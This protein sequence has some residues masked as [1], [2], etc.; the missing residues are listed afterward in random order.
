MRIK[1]LFITILLLS[2]TAA[3]REYQKAKSIN[4][5]VRGTHKIKAVVGESNLP[6]LESMQLIRNV[7][8]KIIRHSESHCFFEFKKTWFGTVEFD[9][10]QIAK[11]QAIEIQI[12]ESAVHHHIVNGNRTKQAS[13]GFHRD[14]IVIEPSH[15]KNYRV[16]LPESNIP[17]NKK[18]PFGLDGILPFRYVEITE[19]CTEAI[20]NGVAQLSLSYNM[21]NSSAN[22]NSADA[23]LNE[24]YELAKHTIKATSFA[25]IYIDG[26]RELKP[27]EADA[28]INQ[29]GHYAIDQDWE[30]ARTTQLY[31]LNNGTWP[32]EWAMHSISMAYEDY[33]RTG[34]KAFILANYTK[35]RARTLIELANQNFLISSANQQSDL[36]E[37]AGIKAEKLI[38]IIDWPINERDGYSTEKIEKLSYYPLLFKIMLKEI[39]L[40]IVEMFDLQYTAKVYSKDIDRLNSSLT[41]IS[42]VNTVVNAFHYDALKKMAY[43]AG[44]INLTDDARLFNE[45]AINVKSSMQKHLFNSKTNLFIDAVGSDNSSMHANVFALRFGLVPNEAKENVA[46]YIY[47][48]KKGSVYLYQYFLEALYLNDFSQKAYTL[49]TSKGRRSWYGMKH[50]NSSTMTTEA[51]DFDI[52]ENM[53]LNHAWG[54]APVNIIPRYL[55][56]ILPIKPGYSE[57]NVLPRDS[58]LK[59]Y[60]IS[61]PTTID[62]I[63]LSK[64]QNQERVRYNLQFEGNKVANVFLLNPINCESNVVS[65]NGVERNINSERERVVFRNLQSGTYEFLFVCK[66]KKD[67]DHRAAKIV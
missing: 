5:Q 38:D 28:Y 58:E 54:T 64:D 3:Y 6:A 19:G 20:E 37:K 50:N 10:T 61:I 53:D 49:L 47:A 27:Y 56:G 23:V 41:K 9:L 1:I 8:S 35:L 14:S 55:A 52:K 25:G 43:L 36:L 67:K 2:G 32:T 11:P 59:R 15:S 57:F 17:N 22:F 40:K 18:L 39:R 62:Y 51:W 33:L 45:R 21:G 30:L 42:K 24:V 29:I 48:R 12:S 66:N 46:E 4:V 7:P 60:D 13:I 63:E 44:E 26:F 31:L 34:D 16:A 65:I